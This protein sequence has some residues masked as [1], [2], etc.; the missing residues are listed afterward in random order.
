MRPLTKVCWL[1]ILVWMCPAWLSA[2]P[3]AVAH[4][5]LLKYAPENTLENFRS[6]LA[7][8]LG[9]EVDVRQSLEGELVCI[10]DETVNRTTN[11]TGRV[12][13]LSLEELQQFDAGSW[14]SS[15]FANTRIPT[16]AQVADMMRQ[17]D[18]TSTCVAIDLKASGIESRVVA[19]ANRADI[20]DQLL[21]IGSAIR[22]QEV[23][24][25]LRLAD[26]QCH[27]ACLADNPEQF[28][29]ALDDPH[30]DW[31]YFR[32]LPTREETIRVHA[33][34]KKAFIAGPTVAEQL[35]ANWRRTIYAQLDAVLTD[36]PLELA[37]LQRQVRRLASHY[38][39][40]AATNHVDRP[41]ESLSYARPG[42]VGIDQRRLEEAVSLVQRSIDSDELRG[43]VLLVARRGKI[44]L[45]K[46]L[47]HRDL[48]RKI[49]MLKETEFRMASNSK[50]VTAAGIL[51]LVQEGLVQLDDPVSVYLPAFEK[52]NSRPITIRQLLTHTSG[53]RISSLFLSP[54]LDHNE[55]DADQHG[56]SQ[57]VREVS[58]FGEI[59][60]EVEPGTTY[61]YNNAGYNTLAGVIEAI[62]GSYREHLRREL[63]VP[64]GMRHS[65]NHES[66]SDHSRMSSVFRMRRDGNWD[67]R[68][69]PGDEPDWPFARGSGGMVSTAVD[70]ATFCH[71]LLNQGVFKGRQILD[72]TLVHQATNPQGD[73]IAAGKSYGLGWV[74]KNAGDRFWHTGSD[75]TFVWI[76]PKRE[77]IG[78]VLTQTQ[79]TNLT[80]PR[81]AFRELVTRACI[82]E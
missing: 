75:G 4:R 68:W 30:S 63:Y 57:L 35:P 24:K 3:V 46:A 64:L 54:L 60:A 70:Y 45:H 2:E 20:L 81:D 78:M 39:T 37:S 67:V 51:L 69:K 15:D 72:P 55:S 31:V 7:L 62:T 27:V 14:F 73:Y 74:V 59:G 50:A 19:V 82:G 71:L 49:P 52:R 43:A 42:D 36:H 47:G 56:G 17:E 66:E 22:D 65:C 48:E 38:A 80:I 21:F 16:F 58:R 26:S 29:A 25:A 40:G 23:R 12:A 8:N 28:D 33:A 9:F 18:I 41:V 44:V 76:D 11:G 32:Y 13:R 61:S 10:H 77:L 6:C 1:L 79:A 34:G 53:L 5:G